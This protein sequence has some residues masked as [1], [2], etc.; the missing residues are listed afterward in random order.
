M[1]HERNRYECFGSL[2]MH[3]SG[4][5]HKEQKSVWAMEKEIHTKRK[6]L[7][8]GLRSLNSNRFCLS[9]Y[10]AFKL[11]KLLD[12]FNTSEDSPSYYI[13][14]NTFWILIKSVTLGFF[15][16]IFFATVAWFFL[17][18]LLFGKMENFQQITAYIGIVIFVQ[19]DE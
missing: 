7:F 9:Y 19:I 11:N 12:L 2:L 14:L 17:L 4:A 10:S 1:Q 8:P 16:F 18:L 6:K 13:Y 15:P 5:Q 3:Q